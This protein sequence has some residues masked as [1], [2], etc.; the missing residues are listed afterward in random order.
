MGIKYLWDT[1]TAIYY[2]QEQFPP[3][4]EKFMDSLLQNGQ[5]VISAI[6]E[7]E[8][9]CWKTATE[10]DI[11]VLQNFINDALVI[12]LEHSIKLKTAE[13]RKSYKIKLPDGIIAAT[14]LVYNLNLVTR[15]LDDFKNIDGI[16][17]INPWEI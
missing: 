7:I 3:N 15:N 12:E 8:L 10:K 5:P 6:T 13:I 9:L 14:A 4:A 1:N 17:L 16:K 11:I 2:L